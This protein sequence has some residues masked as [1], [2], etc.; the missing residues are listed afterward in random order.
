MPILQNTKQVILEKPVTL[1]VGEN[2]TLVVDRGGWEV[3]PEIVDKV[4]R[5]EAVPLV[6][7]TGEGLKNHVKNFLECRQ[8]R[9]RNTNASVEIGA[10]IA[11]FSQLGNIAYRSKADLGWDEIH[12]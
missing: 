3:I 9:N 6:K 4:K 10:H 2:G 11:K 5:M 7:G 12:Q 8:N 1:F